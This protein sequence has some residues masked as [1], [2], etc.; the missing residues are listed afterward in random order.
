MFAT[1]Q[2]AN[3]KPSN[4][5]LFQRDKGND[6]F[7][8]PKLNIGK[9]GDVYEVEADRV[10]DTVV[11][12]A[13]G[14]RNPF[15]GASLA[16]QRKT[17]EEDVQEKRSEGEKEAFQ[18]QQK[19]FVETITPLVR[20]QPQEEGLQ[21]NAED[22]AQLKEEAQLQKRSDAGAGPEEF[23]SLEGNLNS[24]KGGGSPL[25]AATKSEMESGFG[26]DFSG[27]RVHND[28]NAS[29]M[30]QNLGAQAFTHGNDI[31]FNEGK[32]NPQSSSG[33]HLLAHELT[34]TVQ[35]R[36]SVQRKPISISPAPK[37]IQGFGIVDLIPNWI[38]NNARHIPGYTLF[39]VLISYD[40]LLGQAVTRTPIN[41]IEG[42]MGLV[43][44][45]T[46]I[47][48][49]LQELSILQKTFDWI[50]GQLNRLHLTAQ[51][52]LDLVEEAWNEV[53]FPYTNII[54]VITDKFQQ[55]IGRIENF[56]NSLVNQVLT[57]IKEALI[58][59]AEPIL[60]E[61]RAWSL[62]KKII[63]YDPLRDE[64]VVA[65]TIEIL[66]DFLLLIGKETELEQMRERGTLQ[67]TA[68]WLDTQIGNFMSLLSQ[69][70][71][72][73]NSVW[74]AIKPQNL[75]TILDNLRELAVQTTGFLQRVWSFASTV[76]M[77]VL[78][79]LKNALLGWLN[80][81]AAE[82]PGFTLMTVV[83]GKNP[84]TGEDVPRSIENIIRG[85]MG[86]VPGGEA[87]FQ[88]LK[89]SGVVPRAAGQIE[90]LI[91]ELGFSLAY[92]IQ[93]FT[94]MWNSFSIGDLVDP[95]GAFQRTVA[96]F[97]EP[98]SRLFIFVVKVVKVLVALIL[99]IMG[100]PPDMIG[101]IIAN[102]MAAFEDIK[103]DPIG[104]LL[105][106][107]NAV[108]NGFL[109][110]LGNIGTHL[111]SGLQNWL[112]G[113][114][115]DA[116]VQ[117]PSDLSIRSLLGMAMDV[118]GITVDNILE[119]LALR[120]GEERMAKI[121]S[122][123]DRLT[124]IWT[125]VRD[126]IERGPIAIWE[127][128]QSQISN[129][130]NIIK[131]GIMGFIQQKVIQQAIGWLLSFLDVT[132]ILPVIRGVQSIFNA[133]MSFI[134]KLREILGII[135][136]FVAGVADIARGSIVTA[137]AFLETGLADGVPVAISF[138]AK[139][140]G[141]GNISEKIAEM[142]E[143]AREMING[144]IDWLIERALAAG[145]A[146]L[147]ALD[148]G[149]D[150]DEAQN[151]EETHNPEKA[152]Q[153]QAGLNFARTEE[154]RIAVDG[155]ITRA[156]AG[157]VATAVRQNHPVFT[158]FNVIDGDDSWNYKYTASPEEELD[159]AITK[160]DDDSEKLQFVK[161]YLGNKVVD[162]D[163]IPLKTFIN[164]L[165][166]DINKVDENQVYILDNRATGYKF[167]RGAG[168]GVE[169]PMLF[170]E[171]NEGAVG[172][173]KEGESKAYVPLH[174]NYIPDKI[175]MVKAGTIYT[176]TYTTKPFDGV[177]RDEKPPSF[178]IKISF[179]EVLN[180]N[181]NST[182]TRNVKGDNLTFKPEGNPRGATDS[183]GNGFDN[184][185]LIGDRFGGSGRN[186]ALN[187]YPSSP[188]YNR[189]AMLGVE[190]QM[191][192]IFSKGAK[193]YDLTV[194][195]TIQHEKDNNLK[196]ILAEE[197]DED[198]ANKKGGKFEGLSAE[199]A[200][201][202]LIGVLQK[203]INKDL[204][205]VPGQF[206]QVTYA[207]SDHQFNKNAFDSDE[208]S[209]GDVENEKEREFDVH[210]FDVENK[211]VTLGEDSSYKS[212]IEQM[213]SS[214]NRNTEENA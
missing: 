73:I 3:A 128:I 80:S 87:K 196:T 214:D 72:L 102:A 183:A 195:A 178:E 151:L 108:K 114:L 169:Y 30:S 194:N 131:E 82:I 58:G 109:Q 44:F 98:I 134:E 201:T 76:A 176:A 64:E 110:F 38:I 133:I 182:E 54:S 117:I 118:L 34:H 130:W 132:G 202:K 210:N 74:D 103:N 84:L 56:A 164:D 144:A 111:L 1:A 13:N 173:L 105:N 163:G 127:Y 113:T 167:R 35:Q 197:F 209:K 90:T 8:Q 193:S 150:S 125:F 157:E 31:Y 129:L 104:F 83:L 51:G 166:T 33:K 18:I 138:L 181:P 41:L 85:F 7:I 10:A 212:V 161:K 203:E 45:G 172:I 140:L 141:L 89:Q 16:I 36:C 15:F 135:N 86:L 147:N 95:I 148:L 204:K 119:R 154:A 25:P 65:P 77:Q 156:Q 43:P 170:I 171:N 112:F 12:R 81:F 124:G 152:V 208:G 69:L 11:A 78:A 63:H 142:I 160:A 79:L 179:N 26:T 106:L 190:N 101:N 213:E 2:K 42:L 49:K 96:Q 37:M 14:Q 50:S 153:I 9:A 88:E 174:K 67:E 75:P 137:S 24:S 192:A 60:A 100:I 180:D 93:L 61:N 47:F 188:R 55:V 46:A 149:G 66:E 120:I 91:A 29:Q 184:A 17:Q 145:T 121:R 62:I 186:A 206:T 191:A 68:D 116:G 39:T 205:E 155:K 199:E 40:P 187:I 5:S 143:N 22:N 19:P 107:M 71:V 162:N 115:A 139:Q 211:N 23:S 59:I 123:L 97:G 136:S 185:H 158:S 70:S 168:F 198:N 99:E 4:S 57:W 189:R 52:L 32:Y 122:V 92:I 53:S 177:I 48:D 28:S 175:K 207:S 27:V 20:R 6:A 126:V 21:E 146:F 200:E 165:K 94:D 159:T